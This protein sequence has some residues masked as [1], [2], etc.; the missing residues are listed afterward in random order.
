[1]YDPILLDPGPS[2]RGWHRIQS[3]LECPQR[4]AFRHRDPHRVDTGSGSPSLLMGSMVHVGLAHHY[5]RMQARQQGENEN[6]W[7]VPT[8]A[9]GAL[10][11][12][13][14]H[15]AAAFADQAADIVGGYIARYSTEKRKTLHVEEVFS[16]TFDGVEVTARVDHVYEDT[17]GKIWLEDHKTTGRIDTKQPRFYAVSGQILLYRWLGQSLY[18]DRFGGVSLNMVQTASPGFA[19][20]TL[21]AAP[22]LMARFPAVVVEAERRIAELDARGLAT[23][24]WPRSPT[25]LICFH[26]YGACDYLERCKWGA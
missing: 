13:L 15:G 12:K 26:R 16:I 23:D 20:P 7:L 8:A 6:L 4:F 5:R 11:L 10:S 24:D 21:D 19:R 3:F 14:G 22:A 1:M 18:G 25:E 17:A 2:P 9:I